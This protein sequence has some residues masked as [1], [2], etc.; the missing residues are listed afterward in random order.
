M[1]SVEMNAGRQDKVSEGW[2]ARGL[3]H[4]NH[5]PTLITNALCLLQNIRKLSILR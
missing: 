4:Y 2:H 3:F 1:K 5:V